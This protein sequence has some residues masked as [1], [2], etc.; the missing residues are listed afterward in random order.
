[1]RA[2]ATELARSTAGILARVKRGETV[3]VMQRGRPVA[4]IRPRV[5]MTREQ[6]LG[7]VKRN[8]LTSRQRRE[9][10]KACDE[11]ASLFDEC[12]A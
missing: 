7:M 6:L 3:D 11:A 12:G 1:M 10:K 4:T 8:P 5:G 9:L 2:T